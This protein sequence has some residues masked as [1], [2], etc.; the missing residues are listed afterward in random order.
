MIDFCAQR[1]ICV[2]NTYF[3][4]MHKYIRMAKG[5]YGEKVTSMI[6]LMLVKK[7]ILCYVQDGRA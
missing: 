6:D 5:V 2:D 4:H 3:E 7:D 1:D